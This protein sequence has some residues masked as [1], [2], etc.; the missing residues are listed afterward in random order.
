MVG[1]DINA[2]AA[3]QSIAI[4]GSVNQLTIA[5]SILDTSISMGDFNSISIG[6]NVQDSQLQSFIGKKLS[7]GGS[8]VSTGTSPAAASISA[9]SVGQITIKGSILGAANGT[10]STTSLILIS[11]VQPQGWTR[12]CSNT[13]DGGQRN[14]RQR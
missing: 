5:G 11:G 7:I 4:S 3:A 2:A 6:H 13:R 12:S 9:D 1:G 14:N 8:L 10:V